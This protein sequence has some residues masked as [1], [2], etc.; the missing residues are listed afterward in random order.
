M[1]VLYMLI[2]SFLIFSGC[3]S[4]MNN[5]VYDDIPKRNDGGD[6]LVFTQSSV[7]A[8]Y[9]WLKGPFGGVVKKNTL[10]VILYLDDEPHSLR[11]DQALEFYSTMPSM[12]HPMED[13][14]YFEEV[15]KGVYIN[16]SIRFNMPGDWKNELWI[17]DKE[18]NIVDR[19][20]WEMLF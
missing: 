1:N 15:E 7:H 17:M 20:E 9:R 13:A 11:K 8:E 5:R 3:H 16:K 6:Q 2:T 19:L 12:G 18:F 4:P 10:M 14:G